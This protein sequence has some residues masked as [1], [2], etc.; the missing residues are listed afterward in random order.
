MEFNKEDSHQTAPASEPRESI[1]FPKSLL[2]SATSTDLSGIT[3]STQTQAHKAIGTIELLERILYYV[4]ALDLYRARRVSKTFRNTID[5]S[6][7][8]QKN[9]FLKPCAYPPP[10]TIEHEDNHGRNAE[11]HENVHPIIAGYTPKNRK[12]D[13]W[14]SLRSW[15]DN[16][17]EKL[18]ILSCCSLNQLTQTFENVGGVSEDSTL[19]K[20][21]LKNPPVKMVEIDI[22]VPCWNDYGRYT[23][24]CRMPLELD[25]QV[26][27]LSN[28]QGVTFGQVFRY[29]KLAVKGQKKLVLPDPLP[30][31]R[32][33]FR[34]RRLGIGGR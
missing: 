6:L 24:T 7:S 17:G 19:F 16:G 18:P 12:S 23:G 31:H 21:Y 25:A 29:Q 13:F 27:H 9:L 32:G 4:S 15:N 2:S 20:M 11:Y 28:D 5:G 1:P 8:L 26:I 22:R 34:T 14:T 3:N 33:H 10:G 30:K